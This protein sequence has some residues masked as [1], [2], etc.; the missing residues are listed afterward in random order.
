MNSKVMRVSI[1]TVMS[2][3]FLLSAMSTRAYPPFLKA[4]ATFG[5]KDC[6]FCHTKR[7]DAKALNKRGKWLVSE[8]DKRQA[9]TVDVAWLTEYDKKKTASIAPAAKSA[10]DWAEMKG[11]EDVISQ[12]FHPAEKDN[13]APIRKRAGELA[14]KAK[15]WLNSKPPKVYDVP[16]IREM[17]VKLS[18][19]SNE[20]AGSIAKG[21]KNE[22]VKKDLTSLHDRFHEI[23]GACLEEKKKVQ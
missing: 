19:E 11:F 14:L 13:L 9:T 10:E 21:A 6:L 18:A 8:R 15:R 12:T 7:E 2:V 16:E 20:L 1:A 3:G 17:L 4:S 22:Q 23:V 5:A